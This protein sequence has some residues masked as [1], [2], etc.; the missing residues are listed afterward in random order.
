[1][2][3]PERVMLDDAPEGAALYQRHAPTIFAYLLK[4]TARRED[5]ED[6]LL[7]VFLAA[8]E[9]GNLVDLEPP[10][11]RAWLWAVARHKAADH[12]RRLTRHPSM[13]L[14]LV[15]ETLYENEHLEPEQVALRREALGELTSAIAQLPERQQE[16]LRLRFGH[17][18]SCGEMALILKKRESAVRML[19]SRAVKALRK[20]YPSS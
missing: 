5:A 2:Q 19:L 20:L 4:Q 8:M 17:G 7:E 11:Q 12:F 10:E 13:H 14:R 16:V 6:L 9:R 1:M 15:A 3:Q 18:L